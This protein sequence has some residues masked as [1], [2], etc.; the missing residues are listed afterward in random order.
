[1]AGD[2]GI[3]AAQ[4]EPAIGEN[5]NLS[6][7]VRLLQDTCKDRVSA[8]IS[9]AGSANHPHGQASG[10]EWAAAASRYMVPTAAAAISNTD[11]VGKSVST[12]TSPT[13][14][15]IAIKI[16]LRMSSSL[17][18]SVCGTVY[19][20]LHTLNFSGIWLGSRHARQ[21]L[22]GL[23]RLPMELLSGHFQFLHG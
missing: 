9:V 3:F 2:Q 19:P 11:I 6:A 4:A 12:M 23:D 10:P 8:S 18:L 13:S 15:I 1:M 7:E 22:V 5:A 17:Q 21:D 14:L 20:P 16:R